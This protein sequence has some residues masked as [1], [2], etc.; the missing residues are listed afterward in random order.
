MARN[1]KIITGVDIGTTDVRAVIAK[2]NPDRGIN[3]IGAGTVPSS[4]VRKSEILSSEEIVPIVR[5]AV[6]KAEKD[7]DVETNEVYISI[8]GGHIH[9]SRTNSVVNIV[10]GD[11]TVSKEHLNELSEKAK[12]NAE[13]RGRTII[14]CI[15]QEYKLDRQR[16]I[17]N[18]LGLHAARIEGA[19]H[20]VSADK[21]ILENHGRIVNEGGFNVKGIC[22]S[23]IATGNCI[24]NSEDKKD[25]VL[26]IDIGGGST[27]YAIYYNNTVYYSNV[28]AVG[29]D[30][31]TNDL[32]LGL[33]LNYSEAEELKCTYSR[34]HKLSN[35]NSDPNIIN[36]KLLNNE[37]KKV[38]RD[39]VETIIDYR[40]DELLQ[41]VFDDVDRQHLTTLIGNGVVFTGGTTNLFDFS[42]R[43]EKI[44]SMP[45]KIA[46]PKIFRPDNKFSPFDFYTG[47]HEA[48]KDTT[49]STVLG[50]IK[51]AW[52]CEKIEYETKPGFWKRFIGS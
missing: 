24:L 3:I 42:K 51:Y 12:E 33:Q 45:V 30:H 43:T 16:G 34:I 50:L 2:C 13:E 1:E 32:S 28:F 19:F 23:I 36:L 9:S 5:S 38:L 26:L 21:T 47:R 39:D 22:F 41:F 29:G 11:E 7:A 27:S 6:E 37:T 48:L 4:G 52:K 8:G 46:A 18:P 25:G 17:Q 15:P 40:V 35:D 44:F 10:E 31:I 14:H 49:Y 20:I